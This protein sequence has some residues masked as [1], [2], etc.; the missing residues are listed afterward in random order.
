MTDIELAK[1]KLKEQ[2]ETEILKEIETLSQSEKEKIA[3]QINQINFEEIN[4]LYK[5]TKKD[6][7]IKT[8][9]ITPIKY[10][11][12]WKLSKEEK[13]KY[14]KQGEQIIKNN[15]YAVV[16]MAGGQGT[17]LGWKGPKGTYKLNI[18][19]KEKYIFEILTEN[20]MKAKKM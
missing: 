8:G 17:R 11:D 18:G 5:Q 9:N 4:N 6:N 1:S 16:T 10:I 15:Q 20:I 3:K 12:Y 19:K 2:G 13:E 14:Q 7:T